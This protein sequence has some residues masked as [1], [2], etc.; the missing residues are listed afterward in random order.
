MTKRLILIS[1]LFTGLTI[2]Q[3]SACSCVGES[4]VEESFR[5]SDVVAVGRVIQ[6]DTDWIP[7]SA[8]IK[9]MVAHGFLADS[10]DKR[11]YGYYFTRVT[12]QIEKI[13][14]GHAEGDTLTVYTGMGRG[15]CGF[16]F[17]QGQQYVIYGHN[18]SY[19]DVLLDNESLPNGRNVYWTNICTRT[20]EADQEEIR[21]IENQKN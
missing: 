15:D 18:K 8:R 12:V 7:D 5:S 16:R 17:R 19:L 20:R 13:Y 1:L 10:L 11:L 6:S 14:K 3:A 4:S 2:Q 9:E 21:R